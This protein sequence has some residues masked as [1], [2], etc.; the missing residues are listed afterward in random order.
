MTEEFISLKDL[1]SNKIKQDYVDEFDEYNKLD[2]GTIIYQVQGILNKSKALLMKVGV[3]KEVNDVLIKDFEIVSRFKCFMMSKIY[4]QKLLEN[5]PK[6]LLLIKII[7]CQNR[8]PPIPI[9]NLCYNFNHQKSDTII[10]YASVASN[11]IELEGYYNITLHYKEENDNKYV[12]LR[13]FDSHKGN[14]EMMISLTKAL[15]DSTVLEI[16]NDIKI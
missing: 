11:K 8:N 16:L 14:Q 1:K 15:L 12:E 4:S 6:N 10:N 3:T 9:A 7:I 5:N 13:K 2:E